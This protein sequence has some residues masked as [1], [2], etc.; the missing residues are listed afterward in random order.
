M[1]RREGNVTWVS[2]EKFQI[3]PSRPRNRYPFDET[4]LAIITE[5]PKPENEALD[6]NPGFIEAELDTLP[7][8]TK[9]SIEILIFNGVSGTIEEM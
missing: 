9:E 3:G 6:N 4:T 5:L 2:Q 7:P 1:D 8:D